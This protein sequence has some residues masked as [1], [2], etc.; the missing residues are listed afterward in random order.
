V[1]R[2]GDT[3]E[4]GYFICVPHERAAGAWERLLA[5]GKR[6][7]AVCAGSRALEYCMLENN[8]FNIRKEGRCRATPAELQ[9]QWRVS[10]RKTFLFSG[11]LRVMR[12]KP[13]TARLTGVWCAQS[14]A[15]GMDLFCG[16]KEKAVGKVLNA[17]RFLSGPGHIALAMIDL[18]YA[19]SGI[20]SLFVKDA[21]GRA[22]VLTVSPPFVN[23][24]SLN[25]DPQLHS[26]C[27]RDGIAFE[28]LSSVRAFSGDAG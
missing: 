3:G 15:E 11:R 6:Y 28:P 27:D 24:R 2:A 1:M 17:Y 22:A 21:A 16:E 26:Y 9:I 18:P 10:Y 19:V 13:V 5:E 25:V 20:G 14:L 8:F 12:E 7:D 4:Y 23:N